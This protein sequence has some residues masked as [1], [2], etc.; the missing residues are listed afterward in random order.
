MQTK[1]PSIIFLLGPTAS[2]K[3]ALAT[4]WIKSGKPFEIISVDSAMVYKGLNIGTGKPTPL[5]LSQVPHHLIDIREP[6]ESYSAADFR[7]DALQLIPEILARGKIPLL[8]GGTLLYVR[9]LQHGLSPL[10]S[11]DPNVR[12]QLLKEAEEIGWQAMHQRLKDID[13]ATALRIHVNDPQRIQRALEI[14][15]LS[16]KSMSDLFAQEK[17]SDALEAKYQIET[18]A[19]GVE[20]LDSIG[21][22]TLHEN[23][24]K[25]FNHMIEQG[26]IEEVKR[27][28]EKLNQKLPKGEYKNLPAMRSVGYRQVCQYLEGELSYDAMLN[29]A[30]AA[31]RQLAKRQL[32]WLRGLTNINWLTENKI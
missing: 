26:L 3:T 23:I 5:E 25:R 24:A 18:F 31:T 7:A 29:K 10:P 21:R 15:A 11:A 13:P 8:V 17:K 4:E 27:I 19:L 22:G 16:G 20:A 1:K 14:Y 2:G 6:Y 28:L 32:T 30:I 9:A 12:E